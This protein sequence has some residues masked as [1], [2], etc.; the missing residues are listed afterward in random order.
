MM[1][2]LSNVYL[3]VQIHYIKMKQINYVFP[4]V[5]IHYLLILSISGVLQDVLH[6]SI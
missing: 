4:I 5:Q 6:Y 3:I 1:I 2:W